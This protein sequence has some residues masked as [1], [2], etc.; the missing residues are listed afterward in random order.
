MHR[1]LI[2]AQDVTVDEA[3]IKSFYDSGALAKV[4]GPLNTVFVV[5][6][7]AFPV[8][9]G[10]IEGISNPE[11][12]IDR[13]LTHVQDFLKAKGQGVSGKK[14]ELMERVAE[15]FDAH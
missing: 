5:L 12:I 9:C 6:L 4:Y 3:E 7:T 2:D 1:Q 11:K 13:L 8:T 10:P 15:W 14:A